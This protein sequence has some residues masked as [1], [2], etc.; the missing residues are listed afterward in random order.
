MSGVILLAVAALTLS[1]MF[2]AAMWKLQFHYSD[3]VFKDLNPKFWNPYFSWRNKWKYIAMF[4]G[5]K[6]IE[7]FWGSS[8]WFV[9][10]TD[11]FHLMQFFHRLTLFT[12]MGAMLYLRPSHWD[13]WFLVASPLALWAYYATVFSITFKHILAK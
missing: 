3:S 8:R 11:G 9:W 6:S 1:A 7:K 4:S 10:L 2:N 5:E 12:S 13:W